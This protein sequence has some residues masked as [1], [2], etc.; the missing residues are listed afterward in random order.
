M[1]A[2]DLSLSLSRIL[3][4]VCESV[5]R[6]IISTQ[7]RPPPLRSAALYPSA[8]GRTWESQVRPARRILVVSVG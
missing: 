4:S 6:R 5:R 3:K 7:C 8:E 2:S 1:T